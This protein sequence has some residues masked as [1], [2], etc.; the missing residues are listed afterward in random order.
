MIPDSA[1][2]MNNRVLPPD[3]NIGNSDL[4]ATFAGLSRRL[5]D[6][7]LPPQ[8]LS[9]GGRLIETGGLCPRCWVMVNFIGEPCCAVTGRPFAYD[10]GS[11]A[12][13]AE[14]IAEPPNY[15]RAR[16]VSRYDDGTRPLVHALKYRDRLDVAGVLGSL[17][18]FSGNEL[19]EGADL[20]IPVPLYRVRLW[21][22]RYNQSAELAREISKQANVEVRHDILKRVRPTRPQVGLTASQRRR[23]VEGAFSVTDF[24]RPAVAGKR[25]VLVDDVIT[26]GATVNA[27]ASALRRACAEH[28]DV[29]AFARVVDQA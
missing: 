25:V 17:M 27:C 15:H 16:A 14:A 18:A 20:L 4:S 5:V 24:S 10:H 28:V 6:L 22:R 8:C 23:N 2:A 9:C 11:G 29:L 21:R 19:L 1:T 7:V 3:T 26:T 13:S 12:V